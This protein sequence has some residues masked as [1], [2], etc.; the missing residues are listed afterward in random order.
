MP[1]SPS[2]PTAPPPRSSRRFPASSTTSSE[3]AWPATQKV[4]R[5]SPTR[6]SSRRLRTKQP[7]AN[8]MVSQLCFDVEALRTW[9]RKT[10]SLGINL[11]LHLGLAAPMNARKLVELS[12]QIGVGS[13]LRYLSKQHGVIGHLFRGNSY[14]PETLLQRLGA[15]LT[16]PEFNIERPAPVLVQPDHPHRRVATTRRRR[17]LTALNQELD[18]A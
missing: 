5:R 2:V 1:T 8:Y 10:R 15:D 4:T 6:R 17:R 12:V 18:A 3:S 13:S 11:P 7:L 14:R 9:L 16:S